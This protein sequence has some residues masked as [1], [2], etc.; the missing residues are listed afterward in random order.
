MLFTLFPYNYFLNIHKI[1]FFDVSPK[2][3]LLSY[4][5]GGH[6][7]NDTMIMFILCSFIISLPGEKTKLLTRTIECALAT[8]EM[9]KRK[10]YQRYLKEIKKNYSPWRVPHLKGRKLVRWRLHQVQRM[11]PHMSQ[12]NFHLQHQKPLYREWKP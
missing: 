6:N 4:R 10:I 8:S 12:R 1:I 5:C 3:N 2:W 9:E 11:K 7:Y